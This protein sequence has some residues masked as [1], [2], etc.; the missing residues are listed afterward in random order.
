M[1][2]VL[3]DE[4]W[5]AGSF[6]DLSRVRERVTLP[7]LCKEFVIDEVQL[8]VARAMGA[9]AVLLIVRFI[10]DAKRLAE[11]VQAAHER[12]LDPLTEI[13]TEEEAAIALDAGA[14]LVGVNAR[15]LDTLDIDAERTRRVLGGLP[16][17]VVRLHLSSLRTPG[18]VARVA[19]SGVDGALVGE[20]LMRQDDPRDLLSRMVR[21]CGPKPESG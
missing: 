8:D 19:R 9:D 16:A 15:D 3:T 14:E 13:V 11:L 5:F 6:Q 12:Q 7:V 4:H 21:E 2:S 18:D 1:V 17:S 20:A 10:G